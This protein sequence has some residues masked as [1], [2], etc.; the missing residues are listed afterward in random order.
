MEF[1]FSFLLLFSPEPLS[2]RLLPKN[3]KIRIIILTAV[4][5]GCETWSLTLKTENRP[6][7]FENRV[8]RRTFGPKSVKVT[9]SSRKL[10]N[11]ELHNFRSSPSIIRMIKSRKMRWVGHV[12][13][14]A[15]KG[16][17]FKISVVE[18][19]RKR[20]LGRS[21][22]RWMHNVNIDFRHARRERLTTSPPAVR[23]LS[24]QYGIFNISQPYRPLR[25]A[26]RG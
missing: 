9:G 21:K 2:S 20:P 22:C 8:L 3:V 4:M 10:H 1:F 5:Y 11:E 18:T 17:A 23:R 16:N 13:L 6:R 14:M 12:A 7:V 25:L 26:I 19:E 15:E 24:R